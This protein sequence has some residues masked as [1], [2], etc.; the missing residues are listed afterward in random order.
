M[1]VY[2]VEHATERNPQ[3][4]H[5]TG[6]FGARIDYELYEQMCRMPVPSK[7]FDY[8][9]SYVFGSLCVYWLD[10]YLGGRIL[11]ALLDAG[12]VVRVYEV[13]DDAVI[14]DEDRKQCA[15]KPCLACMLKEINSIDQY[16]MQKLYPDMYTIMK[17]AA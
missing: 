14:H 6:A 16:E 10:E 15:F 13:P 11:R 17:E 2:R 4:N 5:Y 9:S 3:S 7:W 8:N 12:C 1:I